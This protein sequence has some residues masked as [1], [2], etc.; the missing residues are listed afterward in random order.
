M[1]ECFTFSLVVF[2][3]VWPYV[4]W[5]YRHKISS[6]FL[7]LLTFTNFHA[8][9]MFYVTIFCLESVS[10]GSHFTSL[11]RLCLL[12]FIYNCLCVWVTSQ[13]WGRTHHWWRENFEGCMKRQGDRQRLEIREGDNRKR[14]RPNKATNPETI[15][16]W[17]GELKSDRIN[18]K[19]NLP[20]IHPV[21]PCPGEVRD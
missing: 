4:Y 7:P 11:G 12:V 21:Q 16:K 5:W 13:S 6:S 19:S 20:G 9:N 14:P 10:L 3:L 15:E 17:L 18:K 8:G 2:T 1:G